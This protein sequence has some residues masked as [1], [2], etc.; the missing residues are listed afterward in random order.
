V[1]RGQLLK[2][3]SQRATA[4]AYLG[5]GRMLA[6]S[7]PEGEGPRTLLSQGSESLLTPEQHVPSGGKTGQNPAAWL[8]KTDPHL[9]FLHPSQQGTVG[10][11]PCEEDSPMA[12]SILPRTWLFGMARPLS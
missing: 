3:R 10:L 5:S 9:S 8:Q 12:L 4:P 1:A 6:R 11:R 2:G 7:Q